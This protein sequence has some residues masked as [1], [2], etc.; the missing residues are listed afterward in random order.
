[1]S[2][3]DNVFGLADLYHVYGNKDSVEGIADFK[4]KIKHAHIAEPVKRRYPLSTAPERPLLP[5]RGMTSLTKA[6]WH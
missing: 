3:A 5:E 4:D 2:K 6:R 1:M